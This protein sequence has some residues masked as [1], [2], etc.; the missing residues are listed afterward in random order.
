MCGEAG[1]L[2]KLINGVKNRFKVSSECDGIFKYVGLQIMCEGNDICVSQNQYYDD[3][4]QLDLN[5]PPGTVLN[6]KQKRDF[7]SLAGQLN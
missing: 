3:I 2:A 1:F 5:L 7:K 4:E 6:D